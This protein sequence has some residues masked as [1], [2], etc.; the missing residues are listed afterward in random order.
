MKDQVTSGVSQDRLAVH[1]VGEY[2]IEKV[3]RS[4]NSGGTW[5]KMV[6]YNS[7]LRQAMI[8]PLVAAPAGTKCAIEHTPLILPVLRKCAAEV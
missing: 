1:N 2:A 8:G 7:L 3:N 5:L 6:R 4:L